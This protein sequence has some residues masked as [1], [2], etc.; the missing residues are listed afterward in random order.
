MFVLVLSATCLYAQERPEGLLIKLDADLS[1][2]TICIRNE[3]YLFVFDRS[4]FLR[5]ELENNLGDEDCFLGDTV[6]L[7][8]TDTDQTL[9]FSCKLRIKYRMTELLDAGRANVYTPDG[10]ILRALEMVYQG[11][12]GFSRSRYSQRYY[13]PDSDTAVLN[14][15]LTFSTGCP[16]F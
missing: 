6:L 13:V 7:D 9:S 4:E 14:Y 16:S 10:R 12:G 15:Y 2:E 1:S 5:G 11:S 8:Y 3:G